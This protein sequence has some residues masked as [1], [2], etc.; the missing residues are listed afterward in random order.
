MARDFVAY[1]NNFYGVNGIYSSGRDIS[2]EDIGYALELL[3][4][5]RPAHNF[6]G[7][8]FDRELIRDIIFS[9]EEQDKMYAIRNNE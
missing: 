9:K 2:G 7:D 5:Q 6:E 3:K 4:K 8:S 1:F